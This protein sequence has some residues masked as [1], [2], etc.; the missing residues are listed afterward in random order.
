MEKFFYIMINVSTIVALITTILF[1]L[2]ILFKI[3]SV[4]TLD[5]FTTCNIQIKACRVSSVVFAILYWFLVSGLPTSECLEGYKALSSIC[6]IWG[7]VW[8]VLAFVNVAISIILGIS[9]RGRD[10]LEMM[11]KMRKSNFVMGAIFL[12]IGFLLKV[13]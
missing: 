4:S 1:V 5:V 3:R 11:R 13:N 8:I 10:E 2:G 12:V 9:K 6:S 7:C